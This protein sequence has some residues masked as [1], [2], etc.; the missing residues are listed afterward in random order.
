MLPNNTCSNNNNHGINLG[1]SDFYVV[2]Y[3]LLQENVG[4]G[5]Y[6]SFISDNNLIH[7]NTFVDNNLGGTSQAYDQGAYNYW[8]DTVTLEGNFWSDWSG[9]G[10]YAIDGT[11]E[12]I[13]LYPFG[14][15]V[16][17]GIIHS[18]SSPTE[19]DTI[20]INTTVTSPYGIQSVTL[21][22]RVNSGTWIE[23]SMTL[24]SGDHYSVTIG[25]YA[26]GDT[27]EYY[28]SAVDNSIN[29]N[30]AIEDNS[31]L[32]YSFTVYEVIPE[33]QTLLPTTI[34]LLFLVF[35]LV[36]LQLRKK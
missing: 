1:S 15:P 33:F 29:Y 18:P 16:I 26:V 3:N 6:V 17:T 9:T 22:Y 2:T 34:T 24:V 12:A 23:V 8:Y 27:I 4:Y 36:V 35:S 11:A 31:G 25:S 10:N 14:P 5:V 32:Y 28:I 30:L 13:D 7:H 19:L 21:H 20:D